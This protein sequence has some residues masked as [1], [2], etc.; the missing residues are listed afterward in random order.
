MQTG[1]SM[2]GA[3]CRGPARRTES[4]WGPAVPGESRE[5]GC[6]RATMRPTATPPCSERLCHLGTDA[7]IGDTVPWL[8]SRA[9]EAPWVAWRFRIIRTARSRSSRLNFLGMVRFSFSWIGTKPRALQALPTRSPGQRHPSRLGPGAGSLTGASATQI[10][11]E[12]RAEPGCRLPSCQTAKRST[13]FLQVGMTGEARR[14]HHGTH[15]GSNGGVR[16]EAQL[17][18]DS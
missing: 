14:Q 7:R 11:D 9:N 15:R 2:R 5:L 13:D 1:A 16:S 12:P 18:R 8:G 17:R 4:E 6:R 3:G 10:F